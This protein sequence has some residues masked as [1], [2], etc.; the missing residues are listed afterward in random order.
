MGRPLNKRNFGNSGDSIQVQFHNGT[1][2]VSGFIVS[3]RGTAKFLCEDDSGNQ[4]TCFL[5]DKDPGD[6]ESGEMIISVRN[7]SDVYQVT[8]ITQHLVTTDV[9][10]PLSW[11]WSWPETDQPGRVEISRYSDNDALEWGGAGAS[12]RQFDANGFSPILVGGFSQDFYAKDGIKDAV[13]D[14]FTV[15]RA[16]EATYFDQNGLIQTAPAN[17]PRDAHHLYE[18]GE[19][20]RKGLLIETEARTNLA[21]YS[22]DSAQFA[23]GGATQDLANNADGPGG[24]NSAIEFFID[25]A[26]GASVNQ[27]LTPAATVSGETTYALSIFLKAGGSD[28]CC[29]RI[30]DGT[31]N[32]NQYFNLVTGTAGGQHASLDLFDDYQ[33][34]GVGN[35]WWRITVIF[36]TSVGVTSLGLSVYS[37]D[38]DGDRIVARDGVSSVIAFGYQIEEVSIKIPY[39]TSYIP[40][41]GTPATRAAETVTIPAA[42]MPAYTTAL[43]F[44]L[45]FR[46]TFADND[47]QNEGQLF[48]WQAGDNYMDGRW[49]TNTG[50]AGAAAAQVRV[51]EDGGAGLATRADNDPIVEGLYGEKSL[52]FSITDTNLQAAYDNNNAQTAVSAGLADFSASDF[53]LAGD[54]HGV[55]EEFVIWDV[56]IEAAGLEA[57]ASRPF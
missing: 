23:K 12:I 17:T 50:I 24:P 43:S 30:D 46:I 57:A 7:D 35:G 6:L 38:D 49:R 15:S 40:T 18:N 47:D 8:K 44:A 31:K 42:N 33:I 37:A 53:S 54:F 22:E 16:S 52:A 51:N 32:H 13:E 34:E 14:V 9:N 21:P 25:S 19:M 56:D 26:G 39:A 10:E 2:S 11:I 27:L 36:E 3:Q 29:L 4:A 1:E 41:N 55:I 20:V 48:L 45:K 28:W 5:V